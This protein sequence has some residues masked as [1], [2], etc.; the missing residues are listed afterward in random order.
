[1]NYYN[2]MNQTDLKSDY[3]F[4]NYAWGDDYHEVLKVRLISLLE[5]IQ[6]KYPNVNGL[7]CVDTSPLMEKVWAQKAGLGWQGKHTNLITKDYGSWIFLGEL[8]IDMQ[9]HYDL[10]FEEDLC[11]TCMSCIEACP[12]QA[13]SEYEIDSEKC[14]SYKT[15]ECREEFFQDEIQLDNWI[16]GCDICQE[17]CP[18]N[19]KFNQVTQKDNFY[20]RSE[21]LK[22]ENIDWE[23][24]NESTF[25]NT[26]K[27]SSAKRAK[28]SG[29]KRNIIKN[30]R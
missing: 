18:W 16:Y 12:T 13:L 15:I 29:L 9:L 4:S 19:I 20:P 8:V 26:F 7:A 3:K 6:V 22:W 2:G 10:P 24:L 27:G 25:K 5:W 28:F 1:M 11:G 30:S 23:N 17:V 14:I 21:I